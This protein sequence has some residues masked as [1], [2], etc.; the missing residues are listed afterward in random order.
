MRQLKDH[1]TIAKLA[2]GVKRFVLPEQ[3]RYIAIWTKHQQWHNLAS[4]FENRRQLLR[5]AEMY[6]KANN[7]YGLERITRAQIE[8][9]PDNQERSLGEPII[10]Q[11]KYRN[12]TELRCVA[13]RVDVWPC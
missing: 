8:F 6:K 13:K 10:V 12:A 5:A 7:N 9:M 11:A 1:E 2:S 4:T 3:W